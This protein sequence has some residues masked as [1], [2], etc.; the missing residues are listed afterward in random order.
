MMSPAAEQDILSGHP[1]PSMCHPRESGDLGLWFL[2]IGSGPSPHPLSPMGRG[3]FLHPLCRVR[4][5][6]AKGSRRKEIGSRLAVWRIQIKF[7]T[8]IYIY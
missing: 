5:S 6:E 1:K 7:L 8:D 2:W 3:G 4:G